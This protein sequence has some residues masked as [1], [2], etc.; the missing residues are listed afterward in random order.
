[1]K[2]VLEPLARVPGVRVAMLATPDGVPIATRGRMTGEA[3]Q[4]NSPAFADSAED[5]NAL[6][7]L[8]T[9]WL[10]ELGRHVGPLAWSTPRRVVLAATRGTMILLEAPNAVLLVLL[11]NGTHEEELRLPMEAALN[12][13]HRVLRGMGRDLAVAPVEEQNLEPTGIFPTKLKLAQD[14]VGDHLSSGT[15][16][17]ETTGEV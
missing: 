9:G 15:Q 16:V 12:R 11:Q 13:I 5:L 17:P 10:S 4:G 14:D 3:G 2:Q 6:A 7:G 1:M 8:A